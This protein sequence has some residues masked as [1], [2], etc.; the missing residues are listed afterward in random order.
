MIVDTRLTV[1]DG[2][3]ER[4]A[5]LSMIEPWADRPYAVT[6]GADKGYD[7]EDFVN[8]LRSMNVHPHVAQNTSGRRSVIAPCFDLGEIPHDAARRQ[9][10]ALRN[11]PR[12]SIS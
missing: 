2:H 12:C 11:S 6:L 10:K 8:E 7:A 3:A 5:A 9:E 1:A 4:G